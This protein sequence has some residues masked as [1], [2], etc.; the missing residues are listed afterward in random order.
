MTVVAIVCVV[1]ASTMMIVMVRRALAEARLAALEVRQA[2]CRW[3][4]ESGLE[5]AAARLAADPN[6]SGEVWKIPARA[7]TGQSN[8]TKQGAGGAVRIEVTALAD[9]PNRRLVRVQADW[10]DD[11]QWRA[12]HT[13]QAT[14]ELGAETKAK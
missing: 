5:R 2:Q 6:Y 7:I 9:Q 4:A 8:E 1:V 12:R 14:V 10:P 13:K 11:P 3:L